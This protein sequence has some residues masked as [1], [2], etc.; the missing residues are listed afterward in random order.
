M[1]G[2]KIHIINGKQIGGV[3]ISSPKKFVLVSSVVVISLFGANMVGS[4]LPDIPVGIN[5]D[6]EIYGPMHES[7]YQGNIIETRWSAFGRTD[8]IAS[9]QEPEMMGVFIDGTAGSPMYQF[10][11]D[12]NN[13]NPIIEDLKFEFPGYFPFFFLGAEEKDSALI[14]GPGGGRDIILAQLGGVK[15][16]DAVEVNQEI[17]EIGRDYAWYNGGIYTDF[18]NLEV[19]IGEGRNFLRGQEQSYDI[20]ILSLPVINTSRSPEGY[21]LTENFLLTIDSIDDYLEHLTAEGRLIFVAHDVF[22]IFRLFSISLASFEER[23]ISN[24]AAMQ[25]MYTVATPEYPL[26]VLKKSPF[27]AADM[28]SRYDYLQEMRYTPHFLYLPGFTQNAE[29][30]PPEEYSGLHDAVTAISKGEMKFTDF[31]NALKENGLNISPVTDNSPFFYNFQVGIPQ[32][33]SLV[34]QLSII[35][36]LIVILVPPFYRLRKDSKSSAR[37]GMSKVFPKNLQTFIVIFSMLGIGFMLAEISLIQRTLLFLGQPV[38]SLS[39]LLF[40]LLAG[41]GIGSLYTNRF[42]VHRI[43]KIVVIGCSI[44]VSMLFIYTFSLP[45]IFN[46]LVG[47]NL[48][49]R[50]LSTAGMLIP[51]GFFMGFLFPSGIRLLKEKEMENNIPWMWGINGTSSVLGSALAML[52]AITIGFKE[53]LLIAAGCYLV[54]LFMFRRIRYQKYIHD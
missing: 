7:S 31:E 38:L 43:L 27:T 23:G 50:L 45:G 13:P 41:V 3:T 33:I 8:L 52:I 28:Q 2:L 39:T 20:I 48:N 40:S 47:M 9:D 17:I 44:V 10:N 21:A 16:I 36:V 34:L 24:E 15:N 11:G 6:K 42:P 37:V 14:I 35:I 53:A 4:N 26:F 51:L 32:P 54:V 1:L 5:P 46:E 29:Y 19:I 30:L 49:M 12:F 18:D 25:H 22:E